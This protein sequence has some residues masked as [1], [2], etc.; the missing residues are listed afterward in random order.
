LEGGWSGARIQLPGRFRS[1]L[2]IDLWVV[3]LLY[4][5]EL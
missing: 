2:M 4:G 3:L 1:S 5:G